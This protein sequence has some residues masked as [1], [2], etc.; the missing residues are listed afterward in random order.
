MASPNQQQKY[1]CPCGKSYYTVHSYY[2]KGGLFD[3]HWEMNCCRCKQ[4]YQ[5]SSF[6]KEAGRGMNEAY[7]WAPINIFSELAVIEGQ[8]Q[9]ARDDRLFLARELCLERWLRYFSG[10][11]TKKEIW[12]R[13]TGQ[14]GQGSGYRLF[15]RTVR[16]NDLAEYLQGYFHY[17]NMDRILKKLG[18]RDIR[19]DE[20]GTRISRLQ[21]RLESLRALMRMEGFAARSEYGRG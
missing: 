21:D 7:I 1:K 20:M 13:L 16:R 4:R 8:L 6:L 11:K 2:D 14:G 15:F 12:R 3:E 9:R 10:A 5:L 17:H 19:L 18:V